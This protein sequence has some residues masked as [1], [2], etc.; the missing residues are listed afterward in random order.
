M[1]KMIFAGTGGAF[2]PMSNASAPVLEALEILR[3]SKE[4]LSCNDIDTVIAK[5][6]QAC[7]PY[8]R[9][10]S[11]VL[12]EKGGK[13]LVIDLGGDARHSIGQLGIKLAD[14]VATYISHTHGDHVY[15]AEW[16]GLMKYFMEIRQG[17]DRP[18]LFG[19]SNVIKRSW[20]N[21]LSCSLE[22]IENNREANLTT[23]FDVRTF[24]PLDPKPF[25]WES[26]AF[27]PF[28]TVH[29]MSGTKIQPSWGLIIQEVADKRPTDDIMQGYYG[30][31]DGD[32]NIKC[33]G[34]GERIFLTTD[35]QFAPTQLNMWYRWATLIMNDCETLGTHLPIND[36]VRKKFRSGVHAHFDDLKGLEAE[37]KKKM[38]LYHYQPNPP[39]EE[40]KDAGFAGFVKTKQEFV[41]N[42]E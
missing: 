10:H 42:K 20:E 26:I 6:D 17:K 23:F 15:G 1:F 8:G 35:T 18:I 33:W 29:V 4:I 27:R 41:I 13:Y 16:F 21:A 3:N 2:A 38:W 30:Y 19:A 14:I 28:Q 9:W 5:L 7:D 31:E 36:P 22:T 40:A 39:I 12:I 37:I 24:D 34:V 25:I 11:N 32:G